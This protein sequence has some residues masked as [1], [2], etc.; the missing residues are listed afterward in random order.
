MTKAGKRFCLLAGVAALTA[1]SAAGG[2]FL[3]PPAVDGPAMVWSDRRNM[4]RSARRH[5]LHP[6]KP[7]QASPD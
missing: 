6:V 1:A 2:S 5:P 4:G 3:R 7:L